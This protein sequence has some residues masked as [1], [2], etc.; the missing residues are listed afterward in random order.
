L[1]PL[2]YAPDGVTSNPAYQP[3]LVVPLPN[4]PTKTYPHYLPPRYTSQVYFRARP[5]LTWP[6][7]SLAAKLLF[8]ARRELRPIVIPA[9]IPPGPGVPGGGLTQADYRELNASKAAE[10][11]RGAIWDWERGVAVVVN[12]PYV[13]PP[14]VPAPP[15]GGAVIA[16][17]APNLPP[18][19]PAAPLAPGLA[20]PPQAPG[21]TLP[22][23]PQLHPQPQPPTQP[24]LDPDLIIPSSDPESAK[25]DTTFWRMRLCGDILAPRP[26]FAPG[27]VFRLGSMRG[28]WQGRIYVSVSFISCSFSLCSF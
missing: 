28:V 19:P 18:S 9:H 6:L 25:W 5:N 16:A 26:V 8:V 15:P 1:L 13:P 14:H 17:G 22:G 4:H 21:P 27:E 24:P 2:P 12:R 23:I 7:A 3:P 11:P 10:L 20:H